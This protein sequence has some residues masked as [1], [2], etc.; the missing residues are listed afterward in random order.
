M[1]NA[2]VSPK[3]NWQQLQLCTK[4]HVCS[5]QVIRCSGSCHTV[6]FRYKQCSQLKRMYRPKIAIHDCK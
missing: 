5:N 6:R 4:R 1:F 3:L 2:T